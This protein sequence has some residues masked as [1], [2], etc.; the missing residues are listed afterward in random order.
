MSRIKAQLGWRSAAPRLEV[1]RNPGPTKEERDRARIEGRVHRVAAKR[2]ADEARDA[3]RRDE[4]RRRE[5]ARLAYERQIDVACANYERV[6]DW[7]A[8]MRVEHPAPELLSDDERRIASALAPLWAA[9]RATIASLRRW[10]DPLVE[11]PFPANRRFAHD[12]VE[13]LRRQVTV[14]RKQNRGRF[15]IP[16]TDTLGT[17]SVMVSDELHSEDSIKFSLAAAALYDGAVLTAIQS[18]SRR[19]LVWEIGGGWGGFARHFKT[20][21]PGA[22]YLITASPARLLVSAVYVMAA[23]PEARC[24]FHLES[25][26]SDTWEGWEQLDFVFASDTALETLH[27]PRPGLTID[28]GELLTMTPA[29]ATAHVRRAYEWGSPYF[30]SLLPTLVA[31][32]PPWQAIE[33]WYWPQPIPPRSEGRSAYAR[34]IAPEHDFSHLVGWRRMR[35]DA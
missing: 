15:L 32:G 17:W 33:R 14:L 34:V 28:L 19:P 21:C 23:F 24:R 13:R 31:G 29:R 12:V 7:A 35:V 2:Q 10:S 4:A 1:Q 9:D 11:A 27:P 25:A 5:Q 22:T 16:E 18:A 6:R 20:L 26:S 8:R 30:Y 3:R